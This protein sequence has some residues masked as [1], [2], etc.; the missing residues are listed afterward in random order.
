MGFL[1]LFTRRDATY[2]RNLILLVVSYFF[3]L[4]NYAQV[5]AASTTFFFEAFGAKSTPV[6]WFWGVFVLSITVYLSSWLQGRFSVQKVFLLMTLL[7]VSIL[8][9]G[10]IGFSGSLKFLAYLPFVWK[11]IYIVLQVHLL[12]GFANIYFPKE[13]FKMLI[14]VVGGI[15]SVGGI[16]GG[17]ITSNLAP[18][19]G[20]I[21]IMWIGIFFCALPAF[22]FVFSDGP[23]VVLETKAR[24]PLASITPSIAKYVALI[25]AIVAVSQFIINIADFNFNVVVEKSISDSSLRTAF[26]GS[27]YT[28][29]N[30]GTL[31]LQLLVMPFVL[32][33]ISQ[34]KYHLFIPTSYF[35]LLLLL[36]STPAA[37]LIGYAAFFVYLKAS[38]YSLFSAGKEILY[39]PLTADQKYG[40]KYL[41]DMLVYRVAKALIAAVLIYFQTSLILNMMMTTFLI[42]WIVIVIRLFKLHRELFN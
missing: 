4:L 37:G 38:D 9:V 15:G 27:I 11:D 35:L 13:D 33:R 10:T 32:P 28:W 6:A 22:I 1:E 29:T 14:G 17:L 2:R 16:L 8:S 12:L 36:I 40:A 26:V 41:T 24:T 34:K 23:K 25:A 19:V 21:S 31:L 3:V 30:T 5:R 42:I 18:V 20:S 7:T 39:Q